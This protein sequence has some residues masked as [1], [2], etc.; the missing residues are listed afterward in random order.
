MLV[1]GFSQVHDCHRDE[2]DADGR[3]GRLAASA[4]DCTRTPKGA[5]VLVKVDAI[6][7]RITRVSWRAIGDISALREAGAARTLVRSA[8]DFLPVHLAQDGIAE[9]NGADEAGSAET[10]ISVCAVAV[11]SA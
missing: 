2:H 9:A 1:A 3:M 6:S 11:D 8:V 10:G 7:R 4:Q 5:G